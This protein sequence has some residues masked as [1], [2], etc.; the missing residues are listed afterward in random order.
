MGVA[1]TEHEPLQ[2]NEEVDVSELKYIE[3][4]GTIR[5]LR[6]L[7]HRGIDATSKNARIYESPTRQHWDAENTKLKI[8]YRESVSHNSIQFVLVI[9]QHLENNTRCRRDLMAEFTKTCTEESTKSQKVEKKSKINKSLKMKR[10][11][12]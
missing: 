3:A 4:I 1:V 10:L 7:K 12:F 5:K 2:I 9:Y 8:S 11:R 6:K